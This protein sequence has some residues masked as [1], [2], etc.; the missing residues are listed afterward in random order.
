MSLVSILSPLSDF[1]SLIAQYFAEIWDFLILVGGASSFIVILVGAI[2]MFVQVRVG[3]T[4]GQKLI[5]S[6]IILAIVIAYFL[7]YPPDFAFD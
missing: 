2:L 1:A 6:G 5:L 3:K 7:M 4:T